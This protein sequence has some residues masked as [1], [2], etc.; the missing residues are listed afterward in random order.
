LFGREVK[1]MEKDHRFNR[2]DFFKTTAIG[3]AVAGLDVLSS[4]ALAQEQQAPAGKDVAWVQA[5]ANEHYLIQ[6]FN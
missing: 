6:R 4:D 5:K 2:R 1:V 3:I